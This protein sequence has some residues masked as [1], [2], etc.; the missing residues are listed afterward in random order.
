MSKAIQKMETIQA[1]DRAFQILETISRSGN[2]TLAEL[3][4]KMN[5][6]KASLSR[7]VYTLVE[8]GYIEKRPNNE[9]SLTLK[10][11]EVGINAVQN[12]DQISLINSTLAD[13]SR[14]TGR[15]AQFSVEDNNQLLCVQSIGQTAPSF[16]V[17]TNVGRRSP[18]YCTSAGKAILST[19]SNHEII[20]KWEKFNVKRL[21]EHTITDVHAL[22]Q[23]ISEVKQRHYALD[24]EENEYNIFCVGALV[25]N[26]TNTPLGAIS[27]SGTTLTQEEEHAISETLIAAVRRLSATLGYVMR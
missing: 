4:E 19:Y 16:S 26:Y 1:I 22:L 20:E 18:L 24:R 23:D 12:L 15:V 13:L 5:I 27:I 14:E 10:A 8:N 6:S 9:Y 21:T 7:L 11:Y 17:Y 2:M 3:H 25:M